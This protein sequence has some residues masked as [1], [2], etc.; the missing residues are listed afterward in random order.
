MACINKVVKILTVLAIWFTFC[1][2]NGLDEGEAA[3]STDPKDP[4]LLMPNFY[5]FDVLEDGEVERRFYLN[6]IALKETNAVYTLNG[7]KE[8]A[9]LRQLSDGRHLIQLIYDA[10]QSLQDC[11]YI[12]DIE[13]ATGFQEKLAAEYRQLSA[14]SLNTSIRIIERRSD[15]PEDLARLAVYR[16][17]KIECRQLHSRMRKAARQSENPSTVSSRRKR[18]IMMLPGTIWCGSGHRATQYKDLG[19]E[20]AVDRCCR[21]HDHCPETIKSSKSKYDITNNRPITISACDCDERF[22]SCL[23]QANT[24][25]SN[26]VGKL[27]FN[28]IQIKCFVLKPEKVCKKSSWWGKC[29][30]NE[31]KKKAHLRDPIPY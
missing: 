27:F 17:M 30:Q 4:V 28:I 3:G 25:A 13:M 19:A 26:L 22:R 20:Q 12:T 5:A 6:G 29:T 24:A 14:I 31:W 21:R 16:R 18:D 10:D 9:V 23:K 11:E 15:L 8:G 7:T 2:A 1:R